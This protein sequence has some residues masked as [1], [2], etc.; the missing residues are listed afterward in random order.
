MTS[1]NCRSRRSGRGSISLEIEP[2]LEVEIV[3]AGA[4]LEIEIDQAG[5]ALPALA[6]VEQH[7]RALHRERGHAGA[8]DRGQEGVDLRLGASRRSPP[9]P[10]RPARRCAPARPE[11]PASPESRRPASAPARARRSRRSDWVT[12]TTG[13]QAPMRAIRRSSACIS[14]GWPASRSMTATVAPSTSKP[15]S[16]RGK[17]AGNNAQLDLLAGAE[18]RARLLLE[19][20]VGGEHDHLGLASPDCWTGQ[21]SW[22]LL[23]IGIAAW[24]AHQLAR[25]DRRGGRA[26]RA[27]SGS[28][29]RWR[30]PPAGLPAAASSTWWSR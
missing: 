17:R 14:S 7:H 27:W 25:S 20:G 15:S 9:V 5:R 26:L 6:A 8:A 13:G 22:H 4:V 30:S 16:M 21:F 3:G 19:A 24:S 11:R 29:R 10:W 28:W 1:S 23:A 2:R 18:G 12:T